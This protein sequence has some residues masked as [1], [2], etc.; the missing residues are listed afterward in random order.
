MSNINWLYTS[1]S[2]A[3]TAAALM[4]FYLVKAPITDVYQLKV[5]FC[6]IMGLVSLVYIWLA[7]HSDY[8]KKMNFVN[9]YALQ[10]VSRLSFLY[11][12]G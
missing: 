9:N 4:I 7:Y 6:I 2:H 11:L 12:K 10:K 1:I 3:T 8:Q 5:A